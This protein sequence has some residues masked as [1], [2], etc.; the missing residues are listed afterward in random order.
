M[1]SKLNL[2]AA[3]EINEEK[4]KELINEQKALAIK[5]QAYQDSKNF[6]RR[7]LG[8]TREPTSE[9]GK[10]LVDPS[11]RLEGLTAGLAETVDTMSVL[12]STV[13]K[14]VEASIALVIEQDQA[15]VN[16]RRATAQPV[17]LME[18]FAILSEIFLQQAC[19]PKKLDNQSSH[20]SLMYLISQ[21][22]QD[23][24][25]NNLQKQLPY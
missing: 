25:K 16:F 10:F 2:L 4:L 20:F 1:R 8:I 18:L 15:V 6:A 11:A 3:E 22:C 5:A 21:R 19:Q 9:F 13:D 24:N 17:S 23:N 7:F 12:T 14:V